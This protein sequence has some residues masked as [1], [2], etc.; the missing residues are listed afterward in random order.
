MDRGVHLRCLLLQATG[1]CDLGGRLGGGV[2][3]QGQAPA[4][5][6]HRARLSPASAP[7]RVEQFFLRQKK[8]TRDGWESMGE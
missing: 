8:G 1:A 3:V 5:Q 2:R 7:T 6:F 4:I